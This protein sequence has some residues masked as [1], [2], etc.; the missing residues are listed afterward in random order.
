MNVSESAIEKALVAQDQGVLALQLAIEQIVG[1]PVRVLVRIAQQNERGE[2]T[3]I[4][5]PVA[6]TSG[7]PVIRVFRHG[8]SL[9]CY[10]QRLV[11]GPMSH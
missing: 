5:T 4:V 1:F 6:L 3:D 8:C 10:A 9:D 2:E 11:F 7:E